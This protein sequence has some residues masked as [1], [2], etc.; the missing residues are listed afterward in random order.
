M[1]VDGAIVEREPDEALETLLRDAERLISGLSAISDV[2]VTLGMQREAP[3]G[4]R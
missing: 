2:I 3:R 4:E 1:D